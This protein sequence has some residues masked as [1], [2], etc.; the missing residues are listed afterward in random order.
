VI[1]RLGNVLD[2]GFEQ[3]FLML[4]PFNMDTGNV[5]DTYVFYKGIQQSDYSFATAIGLFKGTVG[6]ILVVT[7][8]DLT[9]RFGGQGIY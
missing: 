9:K 6:L 3:I 2:T 4:N 5:L 8:N 1:L 7:A